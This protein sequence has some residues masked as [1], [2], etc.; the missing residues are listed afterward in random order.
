MESVAVSRMHSMNYVFGAGHADR[1]ECVVA[2]RG[3]LFT[4]ERARPFVKGVADAWMWD[5]HWPNAPL[6]PAPIVEG[7]K[8]LGVDVSNWT[9][10]G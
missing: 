10:P 8:A 6:T 2:R 7:V 3:V 4:I 5:Y 1:Y 9:P